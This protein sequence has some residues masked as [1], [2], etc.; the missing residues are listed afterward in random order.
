A[1]GADKY[2]AAVRKREIA[3]IRLVRSVLDGI[4]ANADDRANWQQSLAEAPP[5]Q[6]V[7]TADIDHPRVLLAVSAGRVHDEPR[8]RVDPLDFGDRT[9]E[10][11]RLV[12]IEFRRERMMGPNRRGTQ[13][14][15]YTRCH[16][17]RPRFHI[18]SPWFLVSRMPGATA[19]TPHQRFSDP[20]A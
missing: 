3:T 2:R 1:Q 10:H 4:P 15:T 14:K 11:N 8:A 5:Q 7:G 9:L 17:A 20:E 12:R 16:D 19:T 6:D 18:S 13:K